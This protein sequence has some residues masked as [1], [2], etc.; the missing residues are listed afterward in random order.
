MYV[1]NYIKGILVKSR[2]HTNLIT[3][4]KKIYQQWKARGFKLHLHR[5]DNENFA[6]AEEFV[7]SQ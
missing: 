3:A 4:Y 6:E 2:H 5:M 7:T 1:V